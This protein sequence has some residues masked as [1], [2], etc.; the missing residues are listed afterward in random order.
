VSKPRR[1][2]PLALYGAAMALLEPFA[3]GVLRRR[4]AKG[5]E[6]PARLG[7]RLGRATAAR[8]EGRLVWLHGVSVGETVSLLSLVEALRARR[9]DLAILVTSG[10]VTSAQ[11]LA[12]RL[13]KGVIHQFLPVD[14][15]GAV[16]RFLDHWTPSLGVLVE[17]ELWPNLIVGAKARR[18]RLALLSA[19]MT[20]ASAANWARTPQTA[21]ALLGVFDLIAPQDAATAARLTRL[22]AQVGPALNLK[23]IGDAPPA[24][25]AE[26]ERLRG[27]AGG[28]PVILAASTHDGEEALVADAVRK[29]DDRAVL[30][31]APRHPERAA[32]IAADLSASRRSAGQPLGDIHLA[33]TLGEMGLFYRLADIVVMG[34]GWSLGVGG[35]NPLEAARIGRA[36]ITGPGVFNA[37][38]VYAE[39][40]A[41]VAV[42]EAP[43]ADAL[44]R[45]LRGLL[46]YPHIR[47]RMAQAAKTYA[48]RQSGLLDQ[49]LADI[50][51]LVAP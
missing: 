5:K 50:D 23:R 38:D 31:I 27:Q 51:R 19:R 14:T 20:D 42:I 43:D 32:A 37:T 15:P 49:A 17:S 34:G 40:R 44:A 36:L 47:R 33:D 45:H 13:P 8:P 22:G 12:G 3:P 4:A 28:R 11:V 41:E 16:A 39:M 10:T 21:R 7:E 9:P 30:V 25:A 6:D 35:H 48:D 24:D 26:L 2:L 29:L 46:D 18:V 1:T